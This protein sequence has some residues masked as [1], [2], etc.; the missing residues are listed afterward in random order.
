MGGILKYA[1]MWA[2]ILQYDPSRCSVA[3][4]GE[5]QTGYAFGR[6]LLCARHGVVG[7]GWVLVALFCVLLCFVGLI[8]LLV[9]YCC[10]LL[11]FGGVYFP[12]KPGASV[13]HFCVTVP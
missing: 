3:R 4:H 8:W 9:G 10:V 6:C 7:F 1:D 12:A 5:V 13:S 2:G 11:V